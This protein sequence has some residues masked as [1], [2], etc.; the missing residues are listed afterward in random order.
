MSKRAKIDCSE[1]GGSLINKNLRRHRDSGSC[2]TYLCTFCGQSIPIMFKH[3]HLEDHVKNY[4]HPK[5]L[6]TRNESLPSFTIDPSYEELYIRHKIHIRPYIKDTKLSSIFNLQMEYMSGEVINE[7]LRTVFFNQKSSFKLIMSLSVILFNIETGENSF[8][9]ASPNNQLLF[10]EPLVFHSYS[11]LL[12]TEERIDAIDILERVTYPNTKY[13]FRKIT[14]I[15]FYVTK[16]PNHPIGTGSHLPDYLRNNHG[17]ISLT[18]NIKTGKAYNDHLCFFRCLAIHITNNPRSVERLTKE[19]FYKYTENSIITFGGVKLDEL[20][21]ISKLFNVGINVY[22]LDSDRNSRLLVRTIS[23]ENI[24]N[25][26]LY[27]NHF[28]YIKNMSKYCS[29]YLCPSCK[30]CFSRY[31]NLQRHQRTCEDSTT[32][33]YGNGSYKPTDDI[34]DILAT[35]GINIPTCMTLYEYRICFDIECLLSKDLDI[36]STSNTEYEQI[37]KLA[38]V[39]ICS[40]VDGFKEP[41]CYITDGSDD[42]LIERTLDY[43]F[44]IAD[45]VASLQY[46]KFEQ[47]FDMV[48]NTKDTSLLS[49]FYQYIKQVPVLSFNGSRYDLKVIIGPLMRVL[50]RKGELDF[51]IKSG[52]S[53]R[54]IAAKRLKFLDVVA[55]IA[56]GVSYDNFLKAYG[57]SSTK[58]YFPYEYFDDLEKLKS[59]D[60]PPYTAFYS[61]LKDCN[62]L[63]ALPKEK[64]SLSELKALGK[65]PDDKSLL[66]KFECEYVGKFRYNKLKEMFEKRNWSFADYLCHYNNQD[67]KPF[68]EAIDNMIV[69]Y[70]KRGVDIFKQ[71]ISGKLFFFLFHYISLRCTY[72]L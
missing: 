28:S 58:S 23:R 41:R 42:E 37:H 5:Q 54:C 4:I 55:Y 15:V 68:L 32:N 25:L 44:E 61:S 71:A 14:N 18:A 38:S 33:E 72:N 11:D 3:Q 29:S 7:H 21:N 48:A 24:M 22:E 45:K 57:A 30:R 59:Y 17:L 63:E 31:A 16:Q 26:N 13:V 9:K 60:F 70:R 40:N 34:F 47:Y 52:S 19:L 50:V 8:Y 67:V 39:S 1:C 62:T 12:E 10:D 56:P 53:Y 20:E 36:S 2:G 46:Q 69:Y 35:R 66:T 43:M 6:S 27:N 65:N 51:V 49:R 64:L